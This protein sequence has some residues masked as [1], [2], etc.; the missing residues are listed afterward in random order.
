MFTHLK[1]A[2]GPLEG[3]DVRVNAVPTRDIAAVISVW[4]CSYEVPMIFT[5]IRENSMRVL[6]RNA[7]PHRFGPPVLHVYSLRGID[8][9]HMIKGFRRF[10]RLATP[11]SNGS[12]L[13]NPPN[14]PPTITTRLRGDVP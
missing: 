6:I 12:G 2:F 13:A 8:L 3:V 14:P 9:R 1:I 5:A 4:L 11:C 7:Q 10:P